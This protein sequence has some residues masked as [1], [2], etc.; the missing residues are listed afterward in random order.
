LVK[1]SEVPV[2]IASPTD[3]KVTDAKCVYD[4]R[5]HVAKAS[6]WVGWEPTNGGGALGSVTVRWAG[7]QGSTVSVATPQFFDGP[8]TVSTPATKRPTHC[9]IV[10]RFAP[11]TADAVVAF[12]QRRGL[13]ITGIIVYNAAT[14]PEHL[15]GRPGAYLTKVTWQ[16]ADTSQV[17]GVGS[18]GTVEVFSDS[19]AALASARLGD[20]V[21]G[22][23]LLRS[24]AT[25]VGPQGATDARAILR[26]LTLVGFDGVAG[27]ASA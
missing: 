12:L 8:W 6:G 7:A 17:G 5:E 22:P 10:G 18:S 25:P 26:A 19:T 2:S 24:P 21:L 13:P 11:L 16:A 15:L 3:V 20:Y 23:I 4:S 9:A 14:D 27:S 1:P